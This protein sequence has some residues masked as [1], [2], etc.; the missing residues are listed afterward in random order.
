MGFS[1]SWGEN[2]SYLSRR[3]GEASGYVLL[4]GAGRGWGEGGSCGRKPTGW[5]GVAESAGVGS[6]LQQG[7]PHCHAGLGRTLSCK[8]LADPSRSFRE[9]PSPPR[10]P[11]STLRV[12]CSSSTEQAYQVKLKWEWSSH[13]RTSERPGKHPQPRLCPWDSRE[14][15]GT[16]FHEKPGDSRTGDH[17]LTRISLWLSDHHKGPHWMGG[18]RHWA[19]TSRDGK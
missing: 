6:L 17:T 11:F 15:H 8:C 3:T 7:E 4:W 13:L 5:L 1:V 18:A 14:R 10:H 9:T 19:K 12:L 2:V 16:D